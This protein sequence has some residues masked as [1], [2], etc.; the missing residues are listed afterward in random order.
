VYLV[1]LLSTGGSSVD[2]GHPSV[3]SADQENS[4][5]APAETRN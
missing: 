5:R 4:E 3:P 2:G 1:S